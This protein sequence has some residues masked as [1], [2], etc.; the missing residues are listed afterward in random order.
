MP[1]PNDWT[2]IPLTVHLTY[3]IIRYTFYFREYKVIFVADNILDLVPANKVC[4]IIPE[5]KPFLGKPRKR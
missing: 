3:L 5:E 4:K 1:Q 2:Y